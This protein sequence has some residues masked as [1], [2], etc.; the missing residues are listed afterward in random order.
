MPCPL[1][2]TRYTH[3]HHHDHPM[4]PP[5]R[6]FCC[7]LFCC[8]GNTKRSQQ[9]PADILRERGA[10]G[11]ERQRAS[12]QAIWISFQIGLASLVVAGLLKMFGD[13]F[14]QI[15]VFGFVF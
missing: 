8:W 13:L 9:P 4:H 3:G 1:P 12:E 15:I 10:P 2:V 5:Q 6:L 7:Y 11:E 14:V